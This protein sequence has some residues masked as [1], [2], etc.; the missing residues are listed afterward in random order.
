MQKSEK[1]FIFSWK[2]LLVLGLVS[3]TAMGFF[4]TLG[5]HYGKQLHNEVKTGEVAVANLEGSS[6][7][8]PP[9]DALEAGA[10]HVDDASNQAIQKAT[11]KAIE[12]NGLKADHPK[13]VDLPEHKIG[14]AP[15][16]LPAGPTPTV[17]VAKEQPKAADHEPDLATEAE[18]PPAYAIQLGSY[19]T[20]KEATK[21]VSVF[22]KRGLKTEVRTAVVA[23]ETRYRVVMPGFVSKK[24][25]EQKGREMKSSRKIENF[26][27]IKSE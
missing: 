22:S 15:Q 21:K 7:V 14:T 24:L 1:F 5:L 4:F 17:E 26:V 13:P 2:E 10:H 25:A 9:K 19:P 12:E 16:A 27:I 6:E 8:L 3:I 20:S 18:T 11:E 23:G